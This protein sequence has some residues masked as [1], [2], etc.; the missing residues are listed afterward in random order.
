[1]TQEQQLKLDELQTQ[2]FEF[3]NSIEDD[4]DRAESAIDIVCQAIIGG[5]HYFDDHKFILNE[6]GKQY[7]KT[8]KEIFIKDGCW[9]EFQEDNIEYKKL[10]K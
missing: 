7:R 9:E 2:V 10:K 1:M 6:A 8:R 3:I 5:E 4:V